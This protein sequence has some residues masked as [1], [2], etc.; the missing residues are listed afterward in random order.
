MIVG[1]AGITSTSEAHAEDSLFFMSGTRNHPAIEG[2]VSLGSISAA[3]TGFGATA[4]QLGYEASLF[5]V[6]GRIALDPSVATGVTALNA[7]ISSVPVGNRIV[8]IGVSQ[9]NIVASVVEQAEIASGDTRTFLFVR[10]GDP[11]SAE[12][13]MGRNGGIHLPGLTFVTAP[14]ESPWDTVIIAHQYEGLSDW[15][16]QQA[17]LIADINAV[18]GAITYHNPWSYNVDLSSIPASNV[19]V[20]VN[21]LGATTTRYLI[22]AT[23]LLPILRPLQTLGVTDPVLQKLQAVLKPIVDSAYEPLPDPGIAALAQQMFVA[24]VNGMTVMANRSGVM[25]RQAQAAA[26]AAI[27][28]WKASTDKPAPATGASDG[29]PTLRAATTELTATAA[30]SADAATTAAPDS[31]TSSL[32]TSEPKSAASQTPIAG[33]RK[34]T[35]TTAPNDYGASTPD[36]TPATPVG[37]D[38]TANAPSDPESGS[39]S[40]PG[41]TAKPQPRRP[42]RTSHTPMPRPQASIE[43]STGSALNGG[44]E[45]PHAVTPH[46]ESAARTAATNR[47]TQHQSTSEAHDD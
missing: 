26:A 28:R 16:V 18:L 14:A 38:D 23:G 11:S 1:A 44:R 12:G 41:R 4:L 24:S 47:T 39:R 22:P 5:P 31:A 19:T 30:V 9:G 29:T 32:H 6:I 37:S 10:I 35:K 27:A 42:A 34:S 15:P 43:V 3:L 40:G 13:I 17:N 8:I 25:L 7:A 36:A 21:S 20:T 46:A 45:T 2:T 33:P